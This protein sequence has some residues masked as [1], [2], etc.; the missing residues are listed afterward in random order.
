MQK[1]VL[2]RSAVRYVNVRLLIEGLDQG[3]LSAFAERVGKGRETLAR[4]AGRKYHNNQRIGDKLAEDIEAA[5]QLAD[6]YLDRLH[7][8]PDA[9]PPELLAL[10]GGSA[11]RLERDSISIQASEMLPVLDWTAAGQL[12]SGELT[13]IPP[14]A[15]YMLAPVNSVRGYFLQVNVNDYMPYILP[16]M[17]LQ[18]ETERQPTVAEIMERNVF[19]LVKRPEDRIPVLRR[20]RAIGDLILYGP[21][22]ESDPI[23]LVDTEDWIYGGM[24]VM[25]LIP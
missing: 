14:A 17:L 21:V 5:L 11:E 1:P 13:S 19:V 18:V 9:I 10:L 2:N 20:A 12:I 23:G 16:G 25:R 6:G 8:L 4:V 15:R 3:N 7:S 22:N 24:I